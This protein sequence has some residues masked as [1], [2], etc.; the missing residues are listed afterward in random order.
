[1]ATT[2]AEVALSVFT[3]FEDRERFAPT[4]FAHNSLHHALDGVVEWS[5][6]R[7]A[8]RLKKVRQTV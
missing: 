1:M 5:D 4:E 6:A 7:R 2:R 3:E 8:F